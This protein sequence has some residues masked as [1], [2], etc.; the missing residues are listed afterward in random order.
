MFQAC[1]G[2]YPSII[3]S[4]G[5]EVDELGRLVPVAGCFSFSEGAKE[6]SELSEWLGMA[7]EGAAEP[8]ASASR[9]YWRAMAW[10]SCSSSKS[11][12]WLELLR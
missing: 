8:T 4:D 2:V 12:G 9:T 10:T 1:P 6:E 7:G 3:R 5:A 11:L